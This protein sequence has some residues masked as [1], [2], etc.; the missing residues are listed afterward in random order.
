MQKIVEY[1]SPDYSALVCVYFILP[2]FI[3]HIFR[4]F[5]YFIFL[6]FILFTEPRLKGAGAQLREFRV[7]L[8]MFTVF[9]LNV[10]KGLIQYPLSPGLSLIHSAVPGLCHSSYQSD[11]TSFSPLCSAL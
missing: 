7:H 6:Y 8:C 11:P 4:G 10:H 2:Y 1:R 3:L 9:H 5:F